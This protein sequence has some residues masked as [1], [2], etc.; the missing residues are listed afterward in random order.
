MP[1]YTRPHRRKLSK[2]SRT[3]PIYGKGD[4]AGR[5]FRCWN[6][7]WICDTERD[8]LGD[9][10]SNSGDNHTDYHNIAPEDPYTNAGVGR[11]CC[12]GGDIGHFHVAMEI[13]SDGEAKTIRHDYTSDIS[14]GCAFCGTVNWR[15]D[16]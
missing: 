3:L 2:R 9:S 1:T 8:E 14:R 12:L 6:C 7:G 11:S 13:G 4:D 10:D 15:G 16:Y 5:Y